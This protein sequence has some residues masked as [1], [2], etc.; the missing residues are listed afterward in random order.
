MH[1]I[2]TSVTMHQSSFGLLPEGEM[3]CPIQK[4]TVGMVSLLN[5]SQPVTGWS[6]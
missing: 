6:S 5:G 1:Q 3:R 4:H 2:C